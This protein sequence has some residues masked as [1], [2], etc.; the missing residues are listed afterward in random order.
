MSRQ[1][2]TNREVQAAFDDP[3]FAKRFPPILKIPQVAELCQVSISKIEKM[4]ARGELD[5]AKSV[6]GDARF[7]RNRIVAWYFGERG[8]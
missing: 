5:F 4:S 7:W 6:R 3:D 1:K 2:L 8:K